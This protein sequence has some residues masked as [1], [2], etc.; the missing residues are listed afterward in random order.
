[1]L[2]EDTAGDIP[3]MEL[4][5]IMDRDSK[6]GRRVVSVSTRFP[7]RY[8]AVPQ[9][10]IIFDESK[11]IVTLN[12][13]HETYSV[14]MSS[15]DPFILEGDVPE[16]A[17]PTDIERYAKSTGD[18]HMFILLNACQFGWSLLLETSSM[19]DMAGAVAVKTMNNYLS[20]AGDEDMGLDDE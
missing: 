8:T 5:F 9:V 11:T 16:A 19:V 6:G 4:S 17:P 3:E 15:V 1:M 18:I 12:D 14:F 10:P 7:S 13:K 2:S 20:S